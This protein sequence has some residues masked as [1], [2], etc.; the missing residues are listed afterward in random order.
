MLPAL[1]TSLLRGFGIPAVADAVAFPLNLAAI[2]L[3]VR[4][5]R[6]DRRRTSAPGSAR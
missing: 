5:I 1:A 4:E 2:V 3:S 6:A